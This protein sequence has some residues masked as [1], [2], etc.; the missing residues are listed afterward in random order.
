MSHQEYNRK[1]KIATVMLS[2]SILIL[3]LGYVLKLSGC[4]FMLE[5]KPTK[6]IV[7]VDDV[8]CGD[9]TGGDTRILQ[10]SD[11]QS[12]EI[13][14]VCAEGGWAVLV[15]SCKNIGTGCDNSG[16]V[17]FTEDIKPIIETSCLGCHKSPEPYDDVE[18]A[19]RYIDSFIRRV[20]LSADNPSVCHL[21]LGMNYPL[22][23]GKPLPSGRKMDC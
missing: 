23:R 17:T 22:S 16:L 3:V 14:E 19:R 21:F 12:G 15:D 4:G 18:V 5:T 6:K 10:C 8:K 7:L 11:D 13:I 2:S 20:A 9:A 1:L